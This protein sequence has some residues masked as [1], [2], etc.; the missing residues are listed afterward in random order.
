MAD[1]TVSTGAASSIG[2]TAVKDGA[3]NNAILRCMRARKSKKEAVGEGS[4]NH[5]AAPRE[6]KSKKLFDTPRGYPVGV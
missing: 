3:G 6:N 2:S 1:M 4:S 5:V